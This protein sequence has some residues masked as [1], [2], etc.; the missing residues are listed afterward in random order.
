M[1]QARIRDT[2]DGMPAESAAAVPSVVHLPGERVTVP[3]VYFPFGKIRRRDPDAGIAVGLQVAHE[4]Y[5]EVGEVL[6]ELAGY[7]PG[8]VWVREQ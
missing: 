4:T 5:M 6:P 8:G 3:G 7:M 2:V 1:P